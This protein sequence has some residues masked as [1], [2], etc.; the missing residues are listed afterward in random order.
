MTVCALAGGANLDFSYIPT[1]GDMKRVFTANGDYTALTAEKYLNSSDYLQRGDIL[2]R[3]D[4]L[5]DSRHTVM[6]LD[7]GCMVPASVSQPLSGLTIIKIAVNIT[8][9]SDTKME[10]VTEITKVENGVEEPLSDMDSLKLYDWAYTVTPLSSSNKKPSTEA[11]KVSSN[12][13][14]LSLDRLSP[15]NSYSLRITATEHGG[16]A[17]FSSPIITF[18]TAPKETVDTTN[19]EFKTTEPLTRVDRAYINIDGVFKQAI[20]YNN[21]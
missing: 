11:L 16:K 12:A 3:E 4:Y 7:N 14:K 13:T 9:L 17:G 1:C 20:I 21:S 10:A 6:A 5:N 18:T 2:V 15:G 8:R 19:I